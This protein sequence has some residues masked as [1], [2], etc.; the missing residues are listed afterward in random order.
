M[1]DQQQASIAEVHSALLSQPVAVQPLE[2]SVALT[3]HT[4]GQAVA[5]TV[6]ASMAATAAANMGIQPGATHGE[7]DEV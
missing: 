4:K 7:S 2:Q 3:E 6:I 1:Q 5:N